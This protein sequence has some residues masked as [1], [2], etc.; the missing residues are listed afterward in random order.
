MPYR[1]E[2]MVPIYTHY[3]DQVRWYPLNFQGGYEP[4]WWERFEEQFEPRWLE[5]TERELGILPGREPV[6][7]ELFEEQF[8]PDWL[9]RLERQ[10]GIPQPFN[11]R[12]DLPRG[13]Y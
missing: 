7:W 12:F 8:E 3:P 13:A 10:M 1:R 2:Q 9:Q 11:P 6:W 5:R 4:A